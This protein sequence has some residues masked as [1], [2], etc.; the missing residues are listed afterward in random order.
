[1]IKIDTIQELIT[2]ASTKKV[3][4]QGDVVI[5]IW[6]EKDSQGVLTRRIEDIKLRT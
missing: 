5:A 1:M 6:Y 2:L 4:I 3:V